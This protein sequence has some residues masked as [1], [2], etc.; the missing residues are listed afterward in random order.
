[1]SSPAEWGVT[2]AVAAGMSAEHAARVGQGAEAGARQDGGETEKRASSLLAGIGKAL[3]EWESAIGKVGAGDLGMAVMTLSLA[4]AKLL[5]T[6]AAKETPMRPEVW[7]V[8]T[9]QAWEATRGA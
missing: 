3:V 5:R 7:K 2:L 6:M 1:M 8:I 4:A 9:D